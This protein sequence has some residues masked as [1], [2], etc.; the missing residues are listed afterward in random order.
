[1]SGELLLLLIACAWLLGGFA[2]DEFERYFF[3]D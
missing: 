1:M 3:G 2:M